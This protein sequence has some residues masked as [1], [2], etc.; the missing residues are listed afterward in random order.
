MNRTCLISACLFL[1]SPLASLCYI[2]FTDPTY[3]KNTLLKYNVENHRNSYWTTCRKCLPLWMRHREASDQNSA[4]GRRTASVE[5]TSVPLPC[6]KKKGR[7]RWRSSE[8]TQN[9]IISAAAKREKRVRIKLVT[10]NFQTSLKKN[11]RNRPFKLEFLLG[12]SGRLPQ[13]WV[14]H[15]TSYQYGWSHH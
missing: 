15:M 11:E 7:G 10:G 14:Q 5:Q 4:A 2:I 12:K 9:R 6:E 1:T 3:C 13:P 8:G